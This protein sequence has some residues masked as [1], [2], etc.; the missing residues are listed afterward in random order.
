MN[1]TYPSDAAVNAPLCA[2]PVNAPVL[3]TPLELFQ[4]RILLPD[5]Y[6]GPG[7]YAGDKMP[8]G[9]KYLCDDN[10]E[11]A[12]P[13]N[14]IFMGTETLQNDTAQSYSITPDGVPMLMPPK[15]SLLLPLVNLPVTN[16]IYTENLVINDTGISRYVVAGLQDTEYVDNNTN[17]T[18][19]AIN[20]NKTHY[21]VKNANYQFTGG[22]VGI[23]IPPGTEIITQDG[24]ETIEIINSTNYEAQNYIQVTHLSNSSEG[25]INDIQ[26]SNNTITNTSP[27]TIDV[28]MACTE[29]NTIYNQSNAAVKITSGGLV[30]MLQVNQV[31]H[32]NYDAVITLD[33]NIQPVTGNDT[34]KLSGTQVVNN[35]YQVVVQTVDSSLRPAHS[36]KPPK[37]DSLS[38]EKDEPPASQLLGVDCSA[39]NPHVSFIHRFFRDATNAI[40]FVVNGVAQGL[41]TTVKTLP[42]T[43]YDIPADIANIPSFVEGLPA[44]VDALGKTSWKVEKKVNFYAIG[45]DLTNS[46]GKNSSPDVTTNN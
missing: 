30:Y 13:K 40:F 35:Y 18:I 27:F 1:T 33:P 36:V 16:G 23:I 26:A 28:P 11:I 37:L 45:K 3:T 15:S 2:T 44:D 21:I 12:M 20:N 39:I 6:T 46:M 4:L 43:I 8:V 38:N 7:L 5:Y 19:I 17:Y 42:K 41:E 31:Q 14:A 25:V 9:T 29:T 34:D 22:T 32:F 24:R 10:S